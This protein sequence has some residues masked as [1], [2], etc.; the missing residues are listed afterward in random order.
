MPSPKP[1]QV[2]LA[3]TGA[4]VPPA[5]LEGGL[6]DLSL[7]SFPPGSERLRISMGKRD[8]VEGIYVPADP[9]SPVV[10]HLLESEGSITHGTRGLRGYPSLWQLRDLGLSSVVLD[11]RGVGASQG[12]RSPRNLPLDARA[13]W[14]EA[15][16]RAGGDSSRVILRGMSLGTVAAATLLQQEDVKPAAVVLVAPVRAET[17]VKN[18]A[19]HYY[20]EF[21]AVMTT[22][23]VRPSVHV[24]VVETYGKVEVPL[25]VYAPREDYL[26]PGWERLLYE[27]TVQAAGGTW[28]PSRFG[29]PCN[30]LVAHHLF[31]AE[32]ELYR[33]LYPALPPTAA[34]MEAALS[35]LTDEQRQSFSPQSRERQM[36]HA[37]CHR[38]RF[39]PALLSCALARKALTETIEE[40]LIAW[41]RCL[42][43]GALEEVP[44]PALEELLKLDDPAGALDTR[45]LIQ[46]AAYL[47]ELQEQ[48]PHHWKP[49][50]LMR[51]AFE[52]GLHRGVQ[53][54]PVPVEEEDGWVTVEP[55]IDA[56]RLW[57]RA[58]RTFFKAAGLPDRLQDGELEYWRHGAWQPVA[59]ILQ[60][61]GLE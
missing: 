31:P 7:D 26:L 60:S 38:H 23:F 53:S 25:L 15:L 21:L 2:F 32:M 13:A 58:L 1:L 37:F 30:V 49:A 20:P 27:E 56:E 48:H 28:I 41:L 46:L 51:L 54:Q 10:L 9:G 52:I 35:P 47:Q 45:D 17:V 11:Y 59:P 42:P 50:E 61:M 36:L 12:S 16:Q 24:D 55:G 3:A 40:E 39:R 19:R 4:V 57:V 6:P 14:E 5:V 18:W 22:R 33:R 34:R 8:F 29:H 44:L 43:P